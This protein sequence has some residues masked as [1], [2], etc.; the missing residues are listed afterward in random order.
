MA[1]RRLLVC[2]ASLAA[3]AGFAPTVAT[4]S[5]TTHITAA[6]P[7]AVQFSSAPAM[8]AASLH[9]VAVI[10]SFHEPL[11]LSRTVRYHQTLLLWLCQL[12]QH[13]RRDGR[14][15]EAPEQDEDTAAQSKCELCHS[16]ALMS[17]I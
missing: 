13:E 9:N 16:T 4:C 2:A 8:C 15:E 3:V 5:M 14:A 17:L 11:S 10:V 7:G 6:R 1:V 12:S